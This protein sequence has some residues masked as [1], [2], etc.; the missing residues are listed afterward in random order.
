MQIFYAKTGE[1][2]VIVIKI[3][4]FSYWESSTYAEFTWLQ[5]GFFRY[6]RQ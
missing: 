3:V 4:L 2:L 5:L 1:S 6:I